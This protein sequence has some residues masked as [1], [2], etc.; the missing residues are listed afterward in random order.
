[1]VVVVASFIGRGV[2]ISET[3]AVTPTPAYLEIITV[4][5]SPNDAYFV[6]ENNQIGF[7]HWPNLGMPCYYLMSGSVLGLRGEPFTDFV[8]NI[9]TA[10]LPEI[11]GEGPG[12]A[13]PGNGAHA[14]DGPSGWVSVLPNWQ[15]SYEVWLTSEIG[16][17][18][19][20]PVV[21]VPARGCD[22]NWA[23]FN[24]VQVRPLS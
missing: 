18:E 7:R 14:E 5:P 15:V 2:T 23:V 8:V 9:K 24:F 12:Y 6:L 21:V 22:E 16:G 13:F 17:T 1:M 19:L 11:V 4:T 3:S 10:P 20:S